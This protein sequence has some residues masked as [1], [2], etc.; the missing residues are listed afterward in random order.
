MAILNATKGVVTRFPPSPTGYIHIG[1]IR[2]A[3]FNYLFTKQTGGKMVFRVEDTDKERS[4]RE[5]SDSPWGRHLNRMVRKIVMVPAAA[6][7]R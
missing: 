2:T 5:F 7:N 1:S 6:I 3:L 4:K